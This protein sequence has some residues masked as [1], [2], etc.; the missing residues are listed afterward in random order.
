MGEYIETA[1]GRVVK[2]GTAETLYYT[3]PALRQLV[4]DGARRH[5]G[6]LEPRDYLN[7]AHGW[8][9]RFPWP[10]EAGTGDDLDRAC[11]V[12][13]PLRWWHGLE[14]GPVAVQLTPRGVTLERSA[15]TVTAWLSCPLS[16]NPPETAGRPIP[17]TVAV[18]AQKQVDGHLWTLCRCPYCGRLW[19]LDHDRA[20]ALIAHMRDAYAGDDWTLLIADLMEAGYTVEP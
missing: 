9:Y 10:D 2:I 8:H 4:A 19:R 12:R 16:D 5:P 11:I 14:H 6:N 17:Q 3:L 18:C 20:A 15:Y 1:S 7:P 13:V